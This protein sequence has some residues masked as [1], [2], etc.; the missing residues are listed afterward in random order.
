MNKKLEILLEEID[1]IPL[2]SWKHWRDSDWSKHP[3]TTT[4]KYH[5][6]YSGLRA[7]FFIPGETISVSRG[8]SVLDIYYSEKTNP[9]TSKVE[10]Y[11]QEKYK[12]EGQEQ[13][14]IELLRNKEEQERELI[15]QREEKERDLL[16]KKEEQERR[17]R[18]YH[19]DID[20]IL[21][22]RVG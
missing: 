9:I 13:R 7:W 4:D 15:K 21:K 14:E 16:R 1:S 20:E 12:K 19:G 22:M 10:N 5:A 6:H 3:T 2:S 11:I 18:G 17:E 8:Y